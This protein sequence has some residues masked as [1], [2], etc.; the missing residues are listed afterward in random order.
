[1]YVCNC[2]DIEL[3]EKICLCVCVCMSLS[4]GMPLRNLGLKEGY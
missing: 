3:G 4:Q 1:M 2:V